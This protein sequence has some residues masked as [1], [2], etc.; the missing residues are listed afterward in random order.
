MN[1][2]IDR[3]TKT[4]DGVTF[5]NTHYGQKRAYGDS[6]YEYEVSSEMPAEHVEKVCSEQVYKAIPAAQWKAET[7]KG[8]AAYFRA[9]YTFKETSP[10]KYFYQV[11][12]PYTD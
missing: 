4:I 8:A 12:S 3:Q 1:A 5:K 6:Y 7:V 11:C 2:H 9:H 10:G